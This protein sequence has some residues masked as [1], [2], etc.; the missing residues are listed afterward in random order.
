MVNVHELDRPFSFSSIEPDF[1]MLTP[2][3]TTHGDHFARAIKRWLSE[4]GR[5][6]PANPTYLALGVGQAY[7]EVAFARHLRIPPERVTMVDRR[8]ASY[9]RERLTAE[10]DGVDLVESGIFAYIIMPPKKYFSVVGAF[11]IEYVFEKREAP[12]T[13]VAAMQKLVSKGGIVI[14]S[15]YCGKNVDSF[16]RRSGFEVVKGHSGPWSHLM[17]VRG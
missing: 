9:T 15:A 5:D 3:D 13:F 6:L 1:S 7:P 14:I 2:D 10:F 8:I 4:T 17:Y 12:E 11:G 16:W